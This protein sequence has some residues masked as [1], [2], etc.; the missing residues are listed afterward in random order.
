VPTP[1][2]TIE[3]E[4]EGERDVWDKLV[5]AWEEAPLWR[6][7]VVPAVAGLILLC[8]LGAVICLCCCCGRRR[9]GQGGR[10]LGKGGKYKFA[11]VSS[12]GGSERL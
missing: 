2:P 1:T 10:P 9:K 8:L 4:E 6:K 11:D 7:V 12:P 5:D 3:V